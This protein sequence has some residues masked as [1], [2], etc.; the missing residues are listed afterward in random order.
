MTKDEN[1]ASQQDETGKPKWEAPTVISVEVMEVMAAS[2]TDIGDIECD[3]T[4][5]PG[6]DASCGCTTYGS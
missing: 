6:K 2:C 3:G 4:A 5:N 1:K